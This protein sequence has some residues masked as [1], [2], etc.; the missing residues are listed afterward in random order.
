MN[1]AELINKLSA[2]ANV[3]KT[4]AEAV[5]NAFT[6]TVTTE[7]KAGN[8]VALVGFGTFTVKNRAA[9]TG[10]NPSTG[11]PLEI[12]ASKSPTFKAGKTLKSAVN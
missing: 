6:K 12:K 8:A 4:Q 1:K 10:R 11:E 7:L 5:L 3:S 9:R 2:D